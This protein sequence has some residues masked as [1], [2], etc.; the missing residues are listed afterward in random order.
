LSIRFPDQYRIY[1]SHFGWIGNYYSI[2]GNKANPLTENF[3]VR[4]RKEIKKMSTQ[5]PR[6][7]D[8]IRKKEVY[9]F[10]NA[11]K[12]IQNGKACTLN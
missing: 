4:M 3:W 9:A 12:E 8:H 10:P 7:N 2:I 6:E 5:I 11:L 1:I